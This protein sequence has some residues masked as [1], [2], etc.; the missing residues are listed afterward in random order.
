V[1]HGAALGALHQHSDLI[2]YMHRSNSGFID[3]GTVPALTPRGIRWM[4]ACLS[5]LGEMVNSYGGWGGY[6]AAVE[7]VQTYEKVSELAMFTCFSPAFRGWG[8]RRVSAVSS[9]LPAYWRG[10][11][12]ENRISGLRIRCKYCGHQHGV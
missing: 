11:W 1:G 9:V 10:L 7:E 6:V 4:N 2:K 12:H 5:R 3:W 8:L